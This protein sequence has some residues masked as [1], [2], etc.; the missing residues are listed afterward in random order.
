M[1]D[2]V[3][4]KQGKQNDLSS[5]NSEIWKVQTQIADMELKLDELASK[6]SIVRSD[7]QSLED[8][9]KN[10]QAVKNHKIQRL[11]DSL[12]VFRSTLD[13]SFDEKVARLSQTY[14][15]KITNII[16][17]K[18]LEF[19]E[20][21]RSLSDKITVLRNSLADYSDKILEESKTK[22][23]KDAETEIVSL[24]TEHNRNV[25]TIRGD[26]AKLHQESQDLNR[27]ITELHSK[28]DTH[29]Q[30][31]MNGLNSTMLELNKKLEFVQD[32]ESSLGRQLKRLNNSKEE[33]CNKLL[34]LKEDCR[35]YNHEI[36]QF[37]LAIK[38]EEAYR[39]FLHN[40]LQE[41]KGNIR[42]FCR[43]K[44]D[45]EGVFDHAIQSMSC[46][47]GL[48]ESLSISEPASAKPLKK[49]SSS[50][51]KKSVKTYSFFFDKIFDENSSNADI[52]EEISQLVQ[53]SLDGFNVCIFTYGQTGSGKTF[54]MSNNNDGM[55][56]RSMD[57]MFQKIDLLSTLGNNYQLYGQFFEIYGENIR[58]LIDD[59]H[60]HSIKDDSDYH[61][62]PIANSDTNGIKMIRLTSLKQIESL[63]AHATKKRATAATMANDVSSRSHS[64]FKVHITKYSKD[65]SQST[66][67]GTLNLV[68]LAGS[69]RLSHSQVTG[70]RLKETLAINKSLS[71]LGDV[72]ASL[73]AKSSHVPYR[74]SKLTYVLKDSLGGDSKTLMF[75]NISCLS[76]HFNESLS[77]L[78][79]A[80][81]VN[82]TTLKK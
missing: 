52:F 76:S 19:K 70:L 36:E 57:Q 44:P 32:E 82:N 65:S 9:L 77:S 42:V 62:P 53:S 15:E 78:R 28:I 74:N 37:T 5:L 60:Q 38:E 45:R 64:I 43:I 68:D 80:S 3:K 81:K 12:A 24:E 30:P 21:E 48:K 69:E 23:S 61:D 75:V 58:D 27:E 59:D 49:A 18:H 72:I 47:S 35:Q 71:A 40:K 66:V 51:V 1:E 2:I 10:L 4:L 54:T 41:M 6:A 56:P 39:R 26:I 22:I 25:E 13:R 73:K 11:N 8:K 67:I 14:D 50:P 79:F 16:N 33:E 17:S 7:F 31:L 34:Q 20:K 63:L 29:T 46:T 55:I